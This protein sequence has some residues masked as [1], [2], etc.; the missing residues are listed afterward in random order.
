MEKRKITRNRKEA[1]SILKEKNFSSPYA[2][3]GE[4]TKKPKYSNLITKT[5]LIRLSE[6]KKLEK[7][8]FTKKTL[9]KMDKVAK[10]KAPYKLK[11]KT[12]KRNTT[13][14]TITPITSKKS[15]PVKSTLTTFKVPI[16]TEFMR[17]VDVKATSL[18]KAIVQVKGMSQTMKHTW[19]EYGNSRVSEDLASKLN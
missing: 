9:V 16:I 6:L 18:K 1:L 11:I 14:I 8:K 19:E 10:L 15:K 4:I 7:R 5:G 3:L 13:P 2:K 17:V 12:K